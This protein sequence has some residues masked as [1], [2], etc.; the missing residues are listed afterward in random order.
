MRTRTWSISSIYSIY[1]VGQTCTRTVHC[2]ILGNSYTRDWDSYLKKFTLRNEFKLDRKRE[3][4]QGV[5]CFKSVDITNNIHNTAWSTYL[6]CALTEVFCPLT[7]NCDKMHRTHIVPK[8]IFHLKYLL[9]VGGLQQTIH[10][11]THRHKPP[12]WFPWHSSSDIKNK[13]RDTW[14]RRVSLLHVDRGSTHVVQ[15]HVIYSPERNCYT[16]IADSTCILFN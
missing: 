11:Q 9:L 13:Q 15:H 7:A 8:R 1:Q 6:P 16:M 2:L 3:R 12:A 4:V 5:T 14:D 10:R